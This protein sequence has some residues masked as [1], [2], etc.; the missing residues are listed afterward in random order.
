MK[1]K[2]ENI[3]STSTWGLAGML[4]VIVG[5]SMVTPSKSLLQADISS[6]VIGE[7]TWSTENLDVTHFRNGEA[8]F[9]ANSAEAWE[10]ANIEGLP[11]WCYYENNPA[12]GKKY[13]KLYNFWAVSDKR[14]LAPAGWHIPTDAEWDKL[15]ATLGG[16]ENAADAM[17]SAAFGKKSNSTAKASGFAAV[18]GGY[19]SNEGPKYYGGPFFEGGKAGY[20][21]SSTRY[22]VDNS[23][24]RI[25]SVKN[26]KLQKDSFV[27]MAGLSVRLVKD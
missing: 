21:W 10:K 19:R 9:E 25:V 7:Q 24:C 8:L 2:L 12:N 20:W 15:A 6:V 11:A 16:A 17:K 1:S 3:L 14:G 18:P 26:G 27:Q 22:L 13:G 5:M 23:F 4:L